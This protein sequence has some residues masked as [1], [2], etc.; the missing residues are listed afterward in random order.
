MK[1]TY[2]NAQPNFGDMLGP[3]LCDRLYSVEAS[4]ASWSKSDAVMT[5]SLLQQV[6]AGWTGKVLGTGALTAGVKLAP[7]ADVRA[8]RGALSQKSTGRSQLV[9]GDPGIL[10]ALALDADVRER[11]R[12]NCYGDVFIP[13]Y[14]DPRPGV[15]CV[16]N[17]MKTIAQIVKAERVV[18]SSL[19]V[20][21]AADALGVEHCWDPCDEVLGGGFKFHDYVSA[22]GLTITPGEFRLTPRAAMQERVEEL[23]WLL[24]TSIS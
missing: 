8:V 18:S 16:S 13:H 21:I 5:G 17:V 4:W 23:D 11:I 2:W 20:L 10:V 3:W 12:D 22:F 14:I 15:Q 1:L 7:N 24:T 19:H 6:P 9:L